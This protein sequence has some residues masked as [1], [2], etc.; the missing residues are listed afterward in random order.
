MKKHWCLGCDQG[1]V[2]PVRIIKIDKIIFLCE[3][4]ETVWNNE[5]DIGTMKPVNFTN[6]MKENNLE[7]LW[8]ELEELPIEIDD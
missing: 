3:E 6:F 4:C 1:W 5:N 8:S 7:G 2:V